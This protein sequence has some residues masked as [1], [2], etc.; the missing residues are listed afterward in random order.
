MNVMVMVFP[1][2]EKISGGDVTIDP[3]SVYTYHQECFD[4]NILEY[5]K[6]RAQWNTPQD[7]GKVQGNGARIWKRQQDKSLRIYREIGTH[8]HLD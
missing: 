6:F 5:Y 3:V 4:N 7:S 8:N 2:T 1:E